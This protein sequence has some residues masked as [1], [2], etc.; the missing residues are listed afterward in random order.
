MGNSMAFWKLWTPGF[1]TKT[2]AMIRAKLMKA[3]T[4]KK[5]ET[6]KR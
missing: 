6:T 2:G 4:V 5:S 3:R 1:M